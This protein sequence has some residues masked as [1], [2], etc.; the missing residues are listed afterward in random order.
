MVNRIDDHG[1]DH[2][3]GRVNYNSKS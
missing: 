3:N 1:N 2:G